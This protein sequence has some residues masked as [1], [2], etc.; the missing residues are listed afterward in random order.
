MGS[1]I[2]WRRTLMFNGAAILVQA[3]WRERMHRKRMA[4]RIQAAWRMKAAKLYVA[5]L[6][7]TLDPP[8]SIIQNGW[9]RAIRLRYW[10]MIAALAM[11][12]EGHRQMLRR[13]AAASLIIRR[14]R[15]Y[16]HIM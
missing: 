5:N 12:A 11:E 9:R 7:A 16:Q 3:W 15:R 1:A 10:R 4:I 8:V 6:R 2:A 14:Y 13:H